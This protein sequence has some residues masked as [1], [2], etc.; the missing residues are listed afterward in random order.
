MSLV[1][2]NPAAVADQLEKLNAIT[3]DGRGSAVCRTVIEDLRRNDVKGAITVASLDYD[4]VRQ[5]RPMAV[6]FKEVG[7]LADRPML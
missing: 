7:L 3:N 5:Y 1:T 2:E 6:L 4:K